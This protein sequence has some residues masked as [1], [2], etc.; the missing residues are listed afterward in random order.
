MA[1][2][3]P[4]ARHPQAPGDQDRLG[5]PV[6]GALPGG[7]RGAGPLAG[8]SIRRGG[9]AL[10]Q[11]GGGELAGGVVERQRNARRAAVLLARRAPEQAARGQALVQAHGRGQADARRGQGPAVGAE[12]LVRGPDGDGGAVGV[13]GDDVVDG[14]D[15]LV[16]V[17]LDDEHGRAPLLEDGQERV[18]VGRTGRVEVG[19]GLVEHEQRRFDG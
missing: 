14:A 3:P 19:G 13:Q 8:A 6:A 2:P 11:A 10:S 7:V 5:A 18:E 1:A 17:V 15:E 12:D 4:P 9:R 16:Q